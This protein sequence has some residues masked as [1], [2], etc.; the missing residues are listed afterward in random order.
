M[1]QVNTNSTILINTPM[2]FRLLA[3]DHAADNKMRPLPEVEQRAVNV[4]SWI[5]IVMDIL[6]RIGCGARRNFWLNRF[7]RQV[8]SSMPTDVVLLCARWGRLRTTNR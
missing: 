5:V 6:G 3:T 2:A 7:L 8:A 1:L 4:G